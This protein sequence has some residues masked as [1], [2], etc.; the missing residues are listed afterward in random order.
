MDQW[1]EK[2]S[3]SRAGS[4]DSQRLRGWIQDEPVEVLQAGSM[5]EEEQRIES[6]LTKQIADPPQA[7]PLAFWGGPFPDRLRGPVI[8]PSF[9]FAT[10]LRQWV[11]D[12]SC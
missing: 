12:T 9:E 10:A 5:A 7:V 4:K 6:L 11:A 1:D 8:G 2:T 3:A